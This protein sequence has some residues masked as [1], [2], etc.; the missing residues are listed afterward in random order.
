[1]SKTAGKRKTNL[2][3]RD[4]ES[5]IAIPLDTPNPI[6]YISKVVDTIIPPCEL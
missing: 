5:N 1:M 4:E 2:S 6:P 3:R